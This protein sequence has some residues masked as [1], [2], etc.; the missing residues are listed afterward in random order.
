MERVIS[1]QPT[2]ITRLVKVDH[3]Q[4]WSQI[5]WLDQTEM[6]HSIW[7]NNWNFQSFGLNGKGPWWATSQPM[8]ASS[9]FSSLFSVMMCN[10]ASNSGAIFRKAKSASLLYCHAHVFFYFIPWPK[11]GGVEEA[12]FDLPRLLDGYMRRQIHTPKQKGL[13]CWWGKLV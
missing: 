4:S 8:S 13:Q 7:C 10:A 1:V 9:K 3:L 11:L 6:V 5:F 2:K 12:P